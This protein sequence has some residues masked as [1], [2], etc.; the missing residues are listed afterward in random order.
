MLGVATISFWNAVLFAEPGLANDLR[1][2][3]GGHVPERRCFAEWVE[4]LES[5]GGHWFLE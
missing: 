1:V 3:A 5:F 4:V 2:H